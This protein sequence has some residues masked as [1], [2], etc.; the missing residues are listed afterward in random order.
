MNFKT[1]LL[2]VAL[3]L[4]TAATCNE[5]D[6]T[7]N[8]EKDVVEREERTF[9]DYLPTLLLLYTHLAESI[10]KQ[11]SK[12]PLVTL[13]AAAAGFYTNLYMEYSAKKLLRKAKNK[14][15]SFQEREEINKTLYKK[16][17]AAEIGAATFVIA[18]CAWAAHGLTLIA[19]DLRAYLFPTAEE[20]ATKEARQVKSAIALAKSD[21]RK[22]LLKY[23]SGELDAE[24]VPTMCEQTANALKKLGAQCT[25]DELMALFRS[26]TNN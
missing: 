10:K 12:I 5:S 17:L 3:M 20:I 26:L 1:L 15:L 21:F 7:Y 14:E 8:Q 23:K 6:S 22:C 18:T 11:E 13:T 4:F 19:K 16:K 9:G 2:G 24:G 25:V